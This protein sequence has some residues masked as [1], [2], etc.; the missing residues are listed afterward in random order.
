MHDLRGLAD[1]KRGEIVGYL[2]RRTCSWHG[3][4]GKL[5]DARGV[6]STQIQSG[7]N[8]QW[9]FSVVEHAREDCFTCLEIR[10]CGDHVTHGMQRRAVT[11]QR[12]IGRCI[13]HRSWN[14][15]L[16]N[17]IDEILVLESAYG[18]GG[19]SVER[20]K[21]QRVRCVGVCVV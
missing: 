8:V 21:V 10:E 16:W 11:N 15:R 17:R 12:E 14:G 19:S 9:G 3:L 4:V 5:N 20:I 13:E 18:F 1:H 2:P 6:G 7:S